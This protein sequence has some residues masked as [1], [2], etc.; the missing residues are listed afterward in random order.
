MTQQEAEAIYDAGKE[1]VVVVLLMM[2]AHIRA[3]EQ[4]VQP[5]ENQLAKN[6]RNSSNHLQRWLFQE[7]R[8]KKACARRASASP[9]ASSGHTG[10]TAITDKPD[11][12]EVH[13]V[14]VCEHRGRSL[15]DQS[16][17]SIEKRQVQ[18]LP[19]LRLIVTEYQ[20]EIKTCSCG[21]L[22][23][24]T[25]PDGVNAPVQYGEGSRLRRYT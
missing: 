13:R 25:F 21:H 17:D 20:A 8:A 22:N 1:T 7:T 18:D 3:L 24:A 15:A 12:T 4:S 2:D 6:S 5:L 14:K 23:K 10:H 9:A 11:H 16:V 19:P